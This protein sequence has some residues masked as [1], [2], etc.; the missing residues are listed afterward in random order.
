MEKK[1]PPKP[2]NYVEKRDDA[3][4]PDPMQQYKDT[5]GFN[6]P[7]PEPYQQKIEKYDFR[8]DPDFQMQVEQDMSMPVDNLSVNKAIT[9]PEFLTKK[10]GMPSEEALDFMAKEEDVAKTALREV[11]DDVIGGNVIDYLTDVTPEC[12]LPMIKK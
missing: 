2:D 5:L 12:L 8:N 3:Y 7:L 11:M 6:N 9:R 4:T 10:L 1:D